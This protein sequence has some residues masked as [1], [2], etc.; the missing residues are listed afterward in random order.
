MKL[1][2]RAYGTVVFCLLLY[3]TGSPTAGFGSAHSLE[4]GEYV[5]EGGWG[6][7]SISQD[8]DK[9]IFFSIHAVGSN[10][11]TC[12]ELDGEIVKGRTVL[13]PYPELEP[14]TMLFERTA[15]GIKVGPQL[16]RPCGEFC[17]H[18]LDIMEN[19]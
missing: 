5:T 14:C 4:P 1:S 13:Q 16:D 7:L 12:S 18:V 6:T 11:H 17:G 9:R 8:D 19:I 15:N 2:S 3:L 10:G